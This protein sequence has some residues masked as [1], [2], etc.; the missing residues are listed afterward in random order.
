MSRSPNFD[1]SKALNL[2]TRNADDPTYAAYAIHNGLP[3]RRADPA[4]ADRD[5]CC[6]VHADLPPDDN[7]GDP[8]ARRTHA[9][10]PSVQEP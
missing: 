9:R 5:S 2:K 3:F 7:V 10:V 8:H 6:V 4:G 1:K